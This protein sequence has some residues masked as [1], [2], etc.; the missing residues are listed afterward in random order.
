MSFLFG[1]LFA[2]LESVEEGVQS[3][4]VALP[5]TPVP[6]QPYFK[7]LE[8]CGPQGINSALSVHPDVHQPS[9][10]EHSQMLGDLRL[11]EMQLLNHVAYGQGT[12]EQQFDN[13][14]TVGLSEGSESF[15][16][17][18][19]EYASRRIFLSRHI[20]VEEYASRLLHRARKSPAKGNEFKGVSARSR[21]S[22]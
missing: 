21:S 19:F 9:F 15:Q 5:N 20:L 6:L 22:P 10:T 17:G 13:L 12:V 14:K 2:G 7:L 11:A 16:H 4:E 3:L 1:R 18:E 8:R